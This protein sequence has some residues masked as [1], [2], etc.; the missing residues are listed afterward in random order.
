MD[1]PH[2]VDAVDDERGSGRHP[3]RDVENRPIL[4]RVDVLAAEHGVTTLGDA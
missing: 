2:D 1:L 4:G 3:Q